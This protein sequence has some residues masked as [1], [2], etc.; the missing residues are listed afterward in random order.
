MGPLASGARLWEASVL[1]N[2]GSCVQMPTI[3][4][5]S[6][7]TKINALIALATRGP[8]RTRDADSLGIPRIYIQRMVKRGVLERVSRGVYRLADGNISEHHSL[9][10]VAVHA[11]EAIVCLLSALQFHGL[12]TESPSAVWVMLHHKARSP[13][14]DFQRIEVVR[15]SGE[16]LQHGIEVHRIEG[17][18]VRLTSRE[19]TVADCFRYR[20]HVGLDVAIEALRDWLQLRGRSMDALMAAARADRVLSVMRPYLEALA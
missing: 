2:V 13:R 19:K 12:T 5:M 14:L 20:R 18:S 3:C 7:S 6:S 4:N 17:A 16:A 11:P 1:Q 15:A 10:Q 9:V 8:F